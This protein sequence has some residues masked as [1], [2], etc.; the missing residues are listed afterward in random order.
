VATANRGKQVCTCFNVSDIAI[1]Q[2]L[3]RCSGS[4]E[5]RLASLQ[6]ELRCGTNCGSCLPALRKLVQQT[7][8]ATTD[9]APESTPANASATA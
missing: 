5:Q 3:G 7:P 4:T 1:T 8:V 2:V 9:S 6:S